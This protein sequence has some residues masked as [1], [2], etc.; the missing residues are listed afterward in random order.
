[1]IIINNDNT[2][3]IYLLSGFASIALPT[4]LLSHLLS[5]FVFRSNFQTF[6]SR[7]IVTMIYESTILRDVKNSLQIM[8]YDLLIYVKLRIFV[9]KE[10]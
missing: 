10:R 2:Y 4:C 1:M 6:R 7:D 9:N 8:K 5:N 3:C